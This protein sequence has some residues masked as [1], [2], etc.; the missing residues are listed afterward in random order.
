MYPAALR[1]SN[2]TNMLVENDAESIAMYEADASHEMDASSLDWNDPNIFS[3]VI[4]P[5]W[6]NGDLAASM[7]PLEGSS[8][9]HAEDPSASSMNDSPIN[10]DV[11]RPFPCLKHIM[12][13]L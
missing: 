11:W 6:E 9:Y 8:M 5:F 4:N 2:L 3:E 10:G 13:H 1:N 7:E 12:I